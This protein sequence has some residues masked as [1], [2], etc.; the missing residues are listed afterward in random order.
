MIW[1]KHSDLEGKHS[2]LSP[3]KYTWINYDEGRLLEAFSNFNAAQRGTELHAFAAQ[4]I[5]FGQKLAG[6]HTTMSLFVNDAIGYKMT[7]E[8][9]LYYSSRCFGTADAIS[10]RKNFLRIHDL[11]TGTTPAHMEQLEIYAAL[12]CLEYNRNPEDIQIELRLYQN[13]SVIVSN[14]DPGKIKF[15][16]DKAILFTRILDEQDGLIYSNPT[17]NK[18]MKG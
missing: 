14:P 8:Q 18:T 16:M 17:L 1:N 7:P 13:N 2:F 4:A 15:I 10:F 6:N 3:S 5:K 9:P 12:F 11:K